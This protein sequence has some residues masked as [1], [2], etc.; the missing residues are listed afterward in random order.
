MQIV[1]PM[2]GKASRFKNYGISTPKPLLDVLGVPLAVRSAQSIQDFGKN[3]YSFVSLTDHKRWGIESQIKEYF[4]DSKFIY[5]NE[6]TNSPVETCLAVASELDT[7]KPVVFNDCDHVF[8][9][10]KFDDFI[11]EQEVSPTRSGSILFFKSND[12][13]Y[14]Y[15][16]T[17]TIHNFE[18][19]SSAVEKKV[20]S[21]K[22]VCGTYYFN[23]VD[24]FRNLAVETLKNIHN[25]EVYMIELIDILAKNTNQVEAFETI[26]HRSLGTPQEYEDALNDVIFRNTYR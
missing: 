21:N 18:M 4:P 12:P 14:S 24:N 11:R 8:I 5:I 6:P 7:Q 22:A 9:C 25:R 23:S 1:I 16:E 20:I 10:P 15:I 13:K 19:V 17:N 3:Q 2:A 26:F